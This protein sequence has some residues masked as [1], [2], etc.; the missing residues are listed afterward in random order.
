VAPRTAMCIVPDDKPERDLR[1]RSVCG[2]QSLETPM[3]RYLRF[4]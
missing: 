3:V 1:Q 4:R 2:I